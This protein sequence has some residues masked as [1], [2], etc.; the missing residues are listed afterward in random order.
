MNLVPLAPGEL[1]V[2]TLAQAP[3]GCFF[4]SVV[5]LH[6]SAGSGADG[7][8]IVPE[9]TV[10]KGGFYPYDY[11]ALAEPGNSPLAIAAHEMEGVLVITLD[12]PRRV[13]Q[14]DLAPDKAGGDYEICLF[15]LDGDALTTNPTIT[16]R[17]GQALT[18]DFTDR[19]IGMRL[20]RSG[21]PDYEPMARSDLAG[22][23]LR[24]Y[25][26]TPR[27]GLADPVK[28]DDITYF[29]QY[30]GEI[31]ETT[32]STLVPMQ[33]DLQDAV[34]PMVVTG[35]PKPKE[36]NAQP[37]VAAGSMG[38]LDNIINQPYEVTDEGRIDA[39][40]AL[41]DALALY[42]ERL[43]SPL[44][45]D[46]VVKMVVA[47][48]A[49]CR[50]DV[51]S[52][53]VQYYLVLASYTNPGP[54]QVLRFSGSCFTGAQ[55]TLQL[56][57]QATIKTATLKVSESL[58]PDRLAGT[59][60]PESLEGELA[61]FS[62]LYLSGER[63]A[64]SVTRLVEASS[65]C[66]LL[67]AIL[68]LTGDTQLQV[69]LQEDWRG[70]PSGNTLVSS[71]LRLTQAGTRRWERTKFPATTVLPS[72]SYWLLLKAASGRAIWLCRDHNDG[73]AQ[74]PEQQDRTGGWIQ[75]NMIHGTQAL[76]CFLSPHGSISSALTLRCGDQ[77]AALVS[78]ENDVLTFD[79]AKS[80]SDFLE[81]LGDVS[82]ATIP[83]AFASTAQGI[84]TVYPPHIEYEMPVGPSE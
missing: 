33:S 35:S 83:L 6:F 47:S 44:P 12:V 52:S 46:V 18:G 66:G 58:S 59:V 50:L 20:R 56:P 75:Q 49:P 22:L 11:D 8:G 60:T 51:E 16:A 82:H 70:M 76:Y 1:E 67:L 7:I 14:I 54:K 25:P 71:M 78:A 37:V 73:L 65:V 34:M 26:T 4:K 10:I 40:E 55:V 30:A 42:L 5:T 74:I 9:G 23:Y 29:W 72:G 17:H 61:Q 31:R 24:S 43:T 13:R 41:A 2:A 81:T 57:R 48:D 38:T 32:V 62:G 79:L 80:L 45:G 77:S 28:P 84:L 3:S 27:L 36:A 69:E 53:N 63:W 15:R 68:N 64:T 19:R 21:S 39:G